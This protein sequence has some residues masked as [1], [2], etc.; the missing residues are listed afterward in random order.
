MKFNISK[1]AGKI[2]DVVPQSVGK[3]IAVVT[4]K[5]SQNSPEILFAAGVVGIGATVVLSSRATLKC[6]DVIEKHKENEQTAADVFAQQRDD[7]DQNDFMKDRVYIWSRSAVAMAKLYAPAVIAG[8]VTI[9]CFTGSHMILNRRNAGLAAAYATVEKAFEQYRKRV[10]DEFG[11]EKDREFRYNIVEKE[12]KNEEGKKVKKKVVDGEADPS[13]YA[14][15][16]DESN[17][18]WSKNPTENRVFLQLQQNWANDRLIV[19]GHVYLNDIYDSLGMPRTRAG[20]VVGWTLNNDGTDN[21]IDFGC[22]EDDSDFSHVNYVD[23]DPDKGILLDFNVNGVVL[24][25]LKD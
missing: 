23:G 20:S 7:Y 9:A 18:N 21:F 22:F 24:D 14:R 1:F 13:M 10:I 3:K 8:A 12:S 16:F 2:Y 15:I 11:E 25:Y 5:V 19:Q 17:R 6:Q 4:G